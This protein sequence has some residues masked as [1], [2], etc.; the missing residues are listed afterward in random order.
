[1]ESG[2]VKVPVEAGDPETYW[3][4]L[5]GSKG[6]RGAIML[7]KEGKGMWRAIGDVSRPKV[8]GPE[9]VVWRETTLAWGSAAEAKETALEWFNENAPSD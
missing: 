6:L 1:M 9:S 3:L 5:R 4:E 8:K 2:W 7:Q